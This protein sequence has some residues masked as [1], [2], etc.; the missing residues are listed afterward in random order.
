MSRPKYRTEIGDLVGEFEGDLEGLDVGDRVG[1]LRRE[2][3]LQG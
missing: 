2:L 1:T 3:C